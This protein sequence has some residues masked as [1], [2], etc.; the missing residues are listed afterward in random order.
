MPINTLLPADIYIVHNKTILNDFDKEILLSFYEPILGHLPISLYLTLWNDLES[1]QI[2]REY[3][4]HHLLSILRTKL[5]LIKEAR[6]SLEA[7]GLLK[8]YIKKDDINHYVYDLYSP[9]T[10]AEFFNHPILN[11][12]LYNNIGAHEYE[13]LKNKYKKIRIDLK[14]YEEIT[15]PIDKVY[16][17]VGSVPVFDAIERN[18]TDIDCSDQVDFDFIISSIPKDIINERAFNKKTRELINQLSYMYKIDSL[19][20]TELIRSVLNEY[21]MIDKTKLRIAA[22]KQFEYN[23]GALPTLIYRSQPEYL[24]SP[25]GDNSK[26]GKI[27]SLF[28]NIN[29]VDYLRMKNH[30]TKPNNSEM[31]IIEKLIVDMEMTPAVVNV[32]LDYVLRINNNNLNMGFVE[33]IASQWKKA[34]LKTAEEAMEY[35]EKD[36]KRFTKKIQK[37]KPSMAKKAKE[38]IWFNKNVESEEMAPDELAELEEIMK[39]FK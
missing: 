10:P 37:E 14:D 25:S 21:G 3:N 39:E 1:K 20:M 6:T 31:K 26:R 15:M 18:T 32:L 27:I 38:P 5:D 30:G 8:T 36:N 34:N 19:N 33:T 28:E 17:P 16:T 7:V 11:V 9:L 29:P 35:A 13:R 23:S 4:H 24:K 22:R 12:I 2:S